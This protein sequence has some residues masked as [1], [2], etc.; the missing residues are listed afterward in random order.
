[1]KQRRVCATDGDVAAPSVLS[2]SVISS[3]GRGCKLY[4]HCRLPRYRLGK[5]DLDYSP[6]S[7]QKTDKRPV[8]SCKVAS[9]VANAN[10]TFS[11]SPE[12]RFKPIF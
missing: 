5:T 3:S 12:R 8:I 9:A 6:F 1:M 4:R 2:G 10:A 7:S 11:N